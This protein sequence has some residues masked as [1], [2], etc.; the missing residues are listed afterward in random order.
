M[1]PLMLNMC[2]AAGVVID[3]EVVRGGTC[4][5]GCL[6]VLKGTQHGARTLEVAKKKTRKQHTQTT[7]YTTNQ[8]NR[9]VG[10]GNLPRPLRPATVYQSILQV[11]SVRRERERERGREGLGGGWGG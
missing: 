7:L 3:Y 9:H 5:T 4:A 8:L 1:I 6:A 2:V 10:P 11:S